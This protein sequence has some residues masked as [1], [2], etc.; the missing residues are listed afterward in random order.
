MSLPG[1][2]EL[3]RW[4]FYRL[5]AGKVTL[6]GLGRLVRQPYLVLVGYSD[7]DFCQSWG[8]GEVTL[9]YVLVGAGKV[10][11]SGACGLFGRL[12]QGLGGQVR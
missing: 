8:A 4:P 3:L 10:T 5:G 1:A 12:F 11:W 9:P 2:C 7:C 6:L